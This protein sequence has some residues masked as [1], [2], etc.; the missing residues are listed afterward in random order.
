MSGLGS[1]FL[2][3]S[4]FLINIFIYIVNKYVYIINR[5]DYN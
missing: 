5:F 4:H 2:P 3:T 1:L